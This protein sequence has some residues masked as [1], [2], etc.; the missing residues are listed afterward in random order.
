MIS[1]SH[2]RWFPIWKIEGGWR[3]LVDDEIHPTRE[4]AMLALDK[5][6]IGE[7]YMFLD[8][9]KYRKISILL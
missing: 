1:P 9:E 3:K 8:D 5:W 2:K 7:G 4:E 6:L